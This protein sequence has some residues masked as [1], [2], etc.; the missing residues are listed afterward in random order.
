MISDGGE[1]ASH[2]TLNRVLANVAAVGLFDKCDED[3]NPGNLKR[4]PRTAGGE[5][6]LPKETSEV[7]EVRRRI[8][9]DMRDQS[10]VKYLRSNQTFDGTYRM[11]CLTATGRHGA[12]LMVRARQGHIASPA[13]TGT[14][15]GPE[16]GLR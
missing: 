9:K 4:I 14:P 6:L 2:H 3:R 11:S 8:A 13:R 7:A 1:N 15:A 5:A 16:G 12:E 10:A